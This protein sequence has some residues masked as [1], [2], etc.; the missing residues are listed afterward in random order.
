MQKYK[1][2]Q[3]LQ[4]LY[5]QAGLSSSTTAQRPM[6]ADDGDDE[7]EDMDMDI[8][9][10]AEDEDEPSRKRRMSITMLGHYT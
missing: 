7:E 9:E 6:V 4:A 10:D 3:Q 1:D 2:Q 5:Q 8:D